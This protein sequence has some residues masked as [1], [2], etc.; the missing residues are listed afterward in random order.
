[1]PTNQRVPIAYGFARYNHTGHI[2]CH[3]Q[4]WKCSVPRFSVECGQCLA[5][6]TVVHSRNAKPWQDPDRLWTCPVNPHLMYIWCNIYLFYLFI[7]R[8]AVVKLWLRYRHIAID[9]Q[10]YCDVG[11]LLVPY[12]DLWFSLE[13]YDR[14]H[15]LASARVWSINDPNV[16]PSSVQSGRCR[17]TALFRCTTRCYQLPMGLSDLSEYNSPAPPPHLGHSITSAVYYH[18]RFPPRQLLIESPLS[19]PP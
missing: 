17:T 18:S 14:Y 3:G 4:G 2:P 19:H 12:V 7:S 10:A 11:K 16:T 9:L 8:N 13:G 5:N 6:R 1:V 15:S